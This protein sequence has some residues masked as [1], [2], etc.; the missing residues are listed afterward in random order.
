MKRVLFLLLLIPS[1]AHAQMNI[2]GG[3]ILPSPVAGTLVPGASI[4]VAGSSIPIN[5]GG[6]VSVQYITAVTGSAIY[7]TSVVLSVTN[8]SAE[9]VYGRGVNCALSQQLL[10][11][12][13]TGNINPALA[14]G[15]L[16]KTPESAALCVVSTGLGSQVGGVI[17]FAQSP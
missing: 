1:L 2:S 15:F 16:F 5:Q 13:I 3:V 12:P 9:V 8:G 17:G 11:G 10:V 4:A 7:V 14:T 6:A